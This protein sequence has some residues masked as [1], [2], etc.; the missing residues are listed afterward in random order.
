M[1]YVP[2]LLIWMF[3][4]A[5]D[6]QSADQGY[7]NCLRYGMT[8]AQKDEIA[9]WFK[10][11]GVANCCDLSDG[12]PGFAEDRADGVYIAP[13]E[14]VLPIAEAC[15]DHP[16]QPLGDP[17]KDHASWIKGDTGRILH[18]NNP[19]GVVVVWWLSSY[20]A[21]AQRVMWLPR[22]VANLVRI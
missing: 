16:D 5:T 20:S 9:A 2:I 22:C 6:A 10:S 8:D 3:A 14:V 1:K 13:R 19:V 4:F 21:D 12:M 7:F 15:R 18:K 11:D 17:P